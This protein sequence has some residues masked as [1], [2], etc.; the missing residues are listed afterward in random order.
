M[1]NSEPNR[2]AAHFLASK[3]NSS[4]S[5][6]AIDAVQQSALFESTSNPRASFVDKLRGRVG[7]GCYDSFY[8]D[9]RGAVETGLLLR[10]IAFENGVLSSA[11]PTNRSIQDREASK[12]NHV[13]GIFETKLDRESPA[14]GLLDDATMA[15]IKG[16]STNPVYLNGLFSAFSKLNREM[17]VDLTVRFEGCNCLRAADLSRITAEL[18]RG[19]YGFSAVPWLSLESTADRSAKR[20]STIHPCYRDTLIGA[21]C[22]EVDIALKALGGTAHGGLF[23]NAFE[24]Q[25]FLH[26][27]CTARDWGP[28]GQRRIE[29]WENLDDIQCEYPSFLTSEAIFGT[30]AIARWRCLWEATWKGETTGADITASLEHVD[31]YDLSK[32]PGHQNFWAD[33]KTSWS[34]DI[35]ATA[36]SPGAKEVA[37]QGEVL[38][39]KHLP[40][41]PIPVWS[42]QSNDFWMPPAGS[43]GQ[44]QYMLCLLRAAAA[45]TSI[46]MTA[47]AD[48]PTHILENVLS[49]SSAEYRE[50][51][52]QTVTPRWIP[53]EPAVDAQSNSI[54]LGGGV[55]VGAVKPGAL[56]AQV[57][58]PP[59]IMDGDS[60]VAL[61]FVSRHHKTEEALLRLRDNNKTAVALFLY[62]V[63]AL[64]LKDHFASIHPEVPLPSSQRPICTAN[65]IFK[66]HPSASDVAEL[67]SEIFPDKYSRRHMMGRSRVADEV[68]GR[69]D[70]ARLI[71]GSDDISIAATK[72][73]APMRECVVL[74][75]GDVYN[76]D[77]RFGRMHGIILS[78]VFCKIPTWLRRR[79]I[80]FSVW[81]SL[82]RKMGN[83]QD[84]R[85]WFLCNKGR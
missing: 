8:D 16:V 30:D 23:C 44:L 61:R 2:V 76:G 84:C 19:I 15:S 72:E 71:S 47:K 54:F 36:G 55:A 75:N 35:H 39:Q 50:K 82:R 56:T 13:R 81:S 78:V 24:R 9:S 40:H 65:C 6:A 59:A 31:L 21:V 25:K 17:P 34:V 52:P 45:L 79:N 51:E 14:A 20:L 80:H 5:V 63:V 83:G 18:A 10:R 38:C 62:E 53:F 46:L 11:I 41:V 4:A 57:G 70:A 32:S 43:R 27:V 33:I 77:W 67:L 26:N 73:E 7:S 28:N 1:A 37:R 48:A 68:L 3:S 12:L 58:R 60:I 49:S 64:G 69:S 42:S 66:P 74:M 29:R 85:Y 22:L